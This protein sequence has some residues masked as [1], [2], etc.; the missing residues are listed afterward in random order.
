M[1]SYYEH[2]KHP[3]NKEYRDDGCRDVN[4]PVARCF[5]FPK[6][7]HSAMVA[8]PGQAALYPYYTHLALRWHL[9]A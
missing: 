2:P 4:D 1:H 3:P 8:G 7:K 6:I 9:S 5:R